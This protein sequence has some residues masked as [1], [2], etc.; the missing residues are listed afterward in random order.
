MSRIAATFERLAE[1]ERKAL[2]PYVTAGDPQPDV[3]V[4]LLHELVRSGADII[5]LGVPFS[6][7][8]ADGPVIQQACERSLAHGTSLSD[9]L[10]MVR[11][12]RQTDTDTPVVLMGYLNPVEAMGYER[13]A[14][15][16][17]G[18][19]VDGVLLVDLPPEEAAEVRPLTDRHGLDLV[20]LVAPTTSAE[21]MHR[22]AE[23]GSGYIYYVSLKGVTGA[24]TLDPD[25]VARQVE[26]I[27]KTTELPICV[28][29]GIKDPESARAI[30]RV[31]RGVVVGSA[32]VKLAGEHADEPGTVPAHMG[33]TLA[34]MRA[35][36]DDVDSDNRE[37]QSS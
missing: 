8:M 5:E 13:F 26:T 20:F 25:A 2:I 33:A 21:R 19:G 30:S 36:M 34:A 14:A 24:A 23:S 4:P 7:P 12:F 18:A 27:G 28:G 32:L 22:I 16:A 10:G 11:E 17:A 9:V 37:K 31:A 3:T 29:F 15:A 1:R 6:D 35:A